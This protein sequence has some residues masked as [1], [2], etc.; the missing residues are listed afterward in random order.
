MG[1]VKKASVA[2]K[3]SFWRWLVRIGAVMALGV[4]GALATLPYWM[5]G[6]LRLFLPEQQLRFESYERLGY[7]R[8]VLEGLSLSADGVEARVSRLEAPSPL[9]WAWRGLLGGSSENRVSLG[10]LELSLGELPSGEGGGPMAAPRNV[11][12]LWASLERGLQKADPWI[13]ELSVEA[14]AFR[15][16]QRAY[17]ARA[18]LWRE[19]RLVVELDGA[20]PQAGSWTSVSLDLSEPSELRIRAERP[21]AKAAATL[22]IAFEPSGARAALS[23]SFLGNQLEASA[24]FGP[25]VWLPTEAEWRA[26]SW[27]L[28]AEDLGWA[29][30]YS[31]FDASLVGFW[32]AGRWRL[33]VEGGA[34]EGRLDDG[35]PLPEVALKSSLSGNLWGLTLEQLSLRAPGVV[36][37]M[38]EKLAYRWWDGAFKGEAS[39]GVDVDL[40]LFGWDKLEGQLVGEAVFR[41]GPDGSP[42]GRFAFMG[43]GARWGAYQAED[44]DLLGSL[45]WP[46][47]DVERV[48]IGFGGDS[49]LEIVGQ[50]DLEKQEARE[51]SL[52]GKLA[53]DFI[54]A[55][56]PDG[57]SFASIEFDVDGRGSW[58]E[59][60][61]RGRAKVA[62]VVAEALKPLDLEVDWTGRQLRFERLEA[63][64][65]GESTRLA[66]Q[67]SGELEP[68]LARGS[69]T[70]VSL[71]QEGR[72]VLSL[73]KAFAFE[74]ATDVF[75]LD[76]REV[77]LEGE[78]GRVSVDFRLNAAEGTCALAASELDVSA[79]ANPWVARE[80]PRVALGRLSG[81]AKWSEGPVSFDFQLEGKA[82]HQD[83][84]YDCVADLTG[85][86]SG[87]MIR[88]AKVTNGQGA[89]LEFSGQLP[90]SFTL[91]PQRPWLFDEAQALS[92][93]LNARVE[94]GA[95]E[96]ELSA[97]PLSLRSVAASGSLSGTLRDL[98]GSLDF[99]FKSLQASEA[100]ALPEMSVV[101]HAT[102]DRDTMRFDRIDLSML[103][104][105]FGAIGSMIFP[106]DFVSFM[107]LEGERPWEG[108]RFDLEAKDA[109]LSPL[110]YFAPRTL[111]TGG[112]MSA[113]LKGSLRGGID[114]EWR[115]K[116]LSTRPVFPFGA[117]R[118][119]DV[120]LSLEGKKAFLREF[121]G[122]IG[123][124]P[125]TMVGEFDFSRPDDLTYWIDLKGEDLALVRQAGLL[126]RSN[127][128][129]RV[130]RK[131]Q[132]VTG[133][134]GEVEL[135]DGLFLMNLSALGESGGGGARSAASRPPY[136]SVNTPLLRDWT[137]DVAL[138]G[139]RF[140][141]MQTPAATGALSLDMKLG[142]TMSEPF[143][144]GSVKY[145]EGFIVFPFASF[146][147]EGG[148]VEI[149]R[150]NP[151]APK[152]E[153][154]GSARRLGYDLS[155]EVSGDAFDPQL[156]FSSSPALSNEQ[157]LLMVMAGENPQGTFTYSTS[158][159]AS[160]LGSYLSKGLFSSGGSKDGSRFSMATGEN[161]SEQGKE[162]ISM[163]LKLDE[164][165]QFLGEYDEYDSWNVGMRWRIVN[166]DAKEEKEAK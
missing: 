94:G 78:A 53:G 108:V 159:R 46:I 77:S 80:L 23:V 160:K 27:S 136:F 61:H 7:G 97:L 69:V 153:I 133:I 140:M 26:P 123:R 49:R 113:R 110:I 145:D 19:R 42:N 141:R 139:E 64:A 89:A 50:V 151:Y 74:F 21:E 122:V 125:V 119:V 99:E 109:S 11:L 70:A 156:R 79:L 115:I 129:L 36:A 14:I 71:S 143:A 86:A 105:S 12:E 144:I 5:G 96:S 147:V 134:S 3:V 66:V 149:R 138:K 98:A 63:V 75:A 148:R 161:L 91:D 17:S 10:E 85:D 48:D 158:Q 52:K 127:L 88:V 13:S 114:G 67:A 15:Q 104:E 111:A 93:Q 24:V 166:P 62:G 31:S 135:V 56:L 103:E 44:L 83:E 128:D 162:T 152:I 47:L 107:M 40:G 131:S 45:Q 81:F 43:K 55:F 8:F 73:A 165:F 25:D 117:L 18:L 84:L 142:G 150:D 32:K 20:L 112:S 163:E 68:A 72:E 60:E 22:G 121:Q 38:K 120:I 132:Q 100:Y 30:P 164:R 95:L 76:L 92:L 126:L 9:L 39:F 57:L 51:A 87:V 1:I 37:D 59:L 58:A 118:D 102:L 82:L 137:F 16:G 28:S 6:A 90:M 65:L 116:G 33:D 106:S 130:E 146:E 4:A 34:R 41:A 154:L 124:E 2:G 155:I 35:R 54:R 157:I 101:G 29:S